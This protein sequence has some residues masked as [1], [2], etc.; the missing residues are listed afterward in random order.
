MS[1]V[2]QL[3]GKRLR[4]LRQFRTF[5]TLGIFDTQKRFADEVGMDRSHLS[6]LETGKA[7]VSLRVLWRLCC[8]L[9]ISLAQF[10]DSPEFGVPDLEEHNETTPR[11]PADSVPTPAAPGS[12][13]APAEQT[14]GFQAGEKT[15]AKARKRPQEK[16]KVPHGKKSP[17]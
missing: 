16:R 12:G 3:F 7:N 1:T 2:L 5:R 10:F 14:E 9:E 17:G 6:E 4:Q 13:C 15:K 11:A 8:V